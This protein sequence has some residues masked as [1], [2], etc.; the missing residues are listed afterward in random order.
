MYVC[1]YVCMYVFLFSLVCGNSVGQ[2][3]C[4]TLDYTLP[5]ATIRC[6]ACGTRQCV[7]WGERMQPRLGASAQVRNGGARGLRL[8]MMSPGWEC[9]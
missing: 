8:R 2:M 6:W 5:Y 9:G 1:M 3:K 7:T 4:R